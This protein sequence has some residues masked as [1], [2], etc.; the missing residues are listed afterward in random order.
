M[1]DDICLK[2]VSDKPW[3]KKLF[4][5]TPQGRLSTKYKI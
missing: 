1:Y 3:V 4:E 2:S 5:A